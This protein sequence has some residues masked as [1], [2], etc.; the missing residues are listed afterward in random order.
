MR[1]QLISQNFSWD[2]FK[3]A[4][5]M[6]KS[7]FCPM[8]VMVGLGIPWPPQATN[9]TSLVEGLPVRHR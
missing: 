1:N 8:T 3:A 2:F 9:S 7:A 6:G 4:N 5:L